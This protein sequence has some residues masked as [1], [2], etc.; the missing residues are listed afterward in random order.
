M[1]ALSSSSVGRL[2]WTSLLSLA[3][4]RTAQADGWRQVRGGL[5]FRGPGS[6]DCD[7]CQL[8]AEGAAAAEMTDVQCKDWVDGNCPGSAHGCAQANALGYRLGYAGEG[9]APHI[10]RAWLCTAGDPELSSDRSWNC[11]VRKEDGETGGIEFPG[12]RRRRTTT[13]STATETTTTETTTS[14]STSSTSTSSISTSSTSTSS[15]L[16]STT[17]T[18]TTP[19]LTSTTRTT[20]PPDMSQCVDPSGSNYR[21]DWK[22]EGK[23]FFNE[24]EFLQWDSNN[25]AAQYLDRDQAKA[26]NVTIAHDT[27]AILQVGKKGVPMKRKSAKIRTMRNWKYFLAAVRFTHV[28]WG[29]GLWPAFWT[30][31][32]GKRWPEGGELDVLEYANEILSQTSLHTGK[33]NH[34]QI[35]SGQLNKPGCKHFPDLNGMNY[36]CTTD[37]PKKLGCASNSVPLQSPAEWNMHPVTFVIEWTE[38]F[39]KVFKI[40]DYGMPQDL[41]NEDPQPSGWDKW[42]I[43]YYPLA[44]SPGCP[45]PAD[46]LGPQQLIL[47]IGMCGD[48]SGKIWGMSPNCNALNG[49]QNGCRAV[50]PMMEKDLSQDCCT[51]FVEDKDGQY[52]ADEYFR[53]RAFFNISWAKVFQQRPSPGP[54]MR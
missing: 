32:Y 49:P 40:P 7:G 33:E 51:Q 6:G 48:W 30:N 53:S 44:R 47:N 4:V 41:L 45:N 15:T 23:G 42:L 1:P 16:S 36:D 25:G 13:T 52:G 46:V 2:A 39:V 8:V 27:H 37:Y 34:C 22:A 18:T 17:L 9:G 20:T 38:T 14:T 31:A 26:D 21:L 35:D 10:C 11:Y 12:W 5:S 28:P 29:C 19:T 24:W 54:D 3:A 43:S 50:D